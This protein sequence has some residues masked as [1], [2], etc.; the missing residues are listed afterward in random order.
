MK[1]QVGINDSHEE[2]NPEMSPEI[3]RR[4]KYNYANDLVKIQVCASFHMPADQLADTRREVL[5]KLIE[6]CVG[7]SLRRTNTPG[8][9]VLNKDLYGEVTDESIM[10]SNKRNTTR[11][12]GVEYQ[13]LWKV[14]LW[15][16]YLQFL[17]AECP[18]IDVDS[19][20]NKVLAA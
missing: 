1:P 6:L 2:M 11:R 7:A 17:P 4:K 18:K 19:I 16:F 5:L 9:G 12:E 15:S 8:E 3:G 14:A 13:L 10:A 20:L